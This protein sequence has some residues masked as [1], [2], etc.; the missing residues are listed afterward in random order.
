MNAPQAP[1]E[2]RTVGNVR[3][4]LLGGG[5]LA[6]GA[7]IA[8]VV[9]IPPDRLRRWR[10]DDVD[11]RFETLV[12]AIGDERYVEARLSGGFRY[13]PLRAVN[14]A[15]ATLARQNLALLAAAGVL[16]RQAQ[17]KPDID[18]LH[19]WG[20]AQLLL[21][22]ADGAIQNLADANG[23]RPEDAS[24]LADL[25]AAYATRARADNRAED[26]PRALELAARAT[27]LEPRQLE[28]HF[29]KALVLERL[30]L[31]DAAI[32]AWQQYLALDQTSRWRDDATARLR[33]LESLPARSMVGELPPLESANP[34]SVDA[35]AAV[36]SESGQQVRRY[37]N[38]GLPAQWARAVV[39]RDHQKARAVVAA[40]LRLAEWYE[41]EVGDHLPAATFAA[42]SRAD[43][44]SAGGT[45]LADGLQDYKRAADAL[46]SNQPA[47]AATPIRNAMAILDAAGHP[48]R[49]SAAALWSEVLAFDG[50]LAEEA[51]V[52]D[53]VVSA[54]AA[55]QYL[56]PL[57]RAHN[58]LALS[59][60]R[61]DDL[62]GSLRHRRQSLELYRRL[63]DY[64][65]ITAL[66]A[67]VGENYRFLRD[68]PRAWQAA[69]AALQASRRARRLTSMH[70]ALIQPAITA[71]S[72]ALHHV[73][74]AFLD[75][76]IEMGEQHANPVDAVIGYTNRS[77]QFAALQRWQEASADLESA[78]HWLA[79][80]PDAG[81]RARSALEVEQGRAVVAAGRDDAGAMSVLNESV[82][83]FADGQYQ[84][85]LP[86]L[87]RLR[88]DLRIAKGDEAA[89]RSDLEQA[90]AILETQRRNLTIRELRQLQTDDLASIRTRQSELAFRAG[91]AAAAVTLADLG[92]ATTIVEQLAAR[93][94]T[95]TALAPAAGAAPA[96]DAT[97]VYFVVGQAP[98]AVVENP[99]GVTGYRLPCTKDD[100]ESK[101]RQLQRLFRLNAEEVLVRNTLRAL[102][103]CTMAP[104]IGALTTERVIVVP[105]GVFGQ[106]PI[107]ALFDGTRFMAERFSISFAPSRAW[108][109]R[110]PHTPRNFEE[111][112]ILGDPAIAAGGASELPPLPFA[113]EEASAIAALYSH[114]AVFLGPDATAANFL[115]GLGRRGVLHFA[116]HAFAEGTHALGATFATAR[117][118]AA[119]LFLS[120][121]RIAVDTEAHADLVVLASCNV[122]SQ[123]LSGGEGVTVFARPFLALGVSSVLTSLWMVGDRP[124]KELMTRF[125]RSLK[126]TRSPTRALRAAQMSMLHSGETVQSWAPFIVFDSGS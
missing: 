70:L 53:G 49:W 23:D 126:E 81:F 16:Q 14:R 5:L 15:R 118:S 114:A 84:F 56:D 4:W 91:D 33:T 77:E 104:G 43:T 31:T 32:R 94:G 86:L 41:Q 111:L 28:A 97:T 6:A 117:E 29:T 35:L 102:Y 99:E 21:G 74:L 80:I 66:Q 87:F 3:P 44:N 12:A 113:R 100:L 124:T 110:Q 92:R 25:A 68:Y 71:E 69:F 109:A 101:V 30:G 125:H 76:L 17:L 64:D 51:R 78:Q 108:L 116:G 1:E 37:L 19:A 90:A 40:A 39:E 54:A 9:W 58:R 105:E 48:L 79:R 123:G 85:R 122:A 59:R 11:P 27:T 38:E 93:R 24:L 36:L 107:P 57:A 60:L 121:Y 62:E 67:N 61:H 96:T 26:W 7:A 2:V 34:L 45:R 82:R 46:E 88:A 106:V 18:N 98:F 83:A 72:Q 55:Q 22:D 89:A 8:L 75:R 42:L 63:R 47:Q 73:S 119:D 120:A 103:D 115:A 95:S 112:S 20:V 65:R 50:Q 52:L 13:G 10:G